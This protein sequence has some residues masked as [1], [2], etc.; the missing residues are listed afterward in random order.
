MT[1]DRDPLALYLL[2]LCVVSGLA[3]ITRHP[4]PGIPGWLGAT[5]AVVLVAGGGTALV[6]KTLASPAW[7]YLVERIGLYPLGGAALGFGAALI[8][9]GA[10]LSGTVTV[11]FGLAV[12]IRI[13][14]I[15][16]RIQ[17]ARVHQ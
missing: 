9:V 12:A 3:S 7:G 14:Q 17:R 1:R 15:T 13:T 6:G 10:T 8:A 2:G 16:R 5:W 4:V 11:V